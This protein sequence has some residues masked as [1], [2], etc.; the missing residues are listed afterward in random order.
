[1]LK[2]GTFEIVLR[3]DIPQNT[4]VLKGRFFLVVKHKDTKGELFKARYVVQG[5]ADPLMKQ[6]VHN[7]PNLRQDISR[8]ILAMA[9][10]LGFETRTLDI[11]MAFLLATSTN[12]REQYLEPSKESNRSSKNRLKLVKSLYGLCESGDRWHSPLRHHPCNRLAN[13]TVDNRY[14]SVLSTSC[15]AFNRNV[16]L[17]C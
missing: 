7:S 9:S 4:T 14:R 8:L 5:F 2:R 16:R 6:A 13:G 10:V 17:L 12:M 1:L 11:S 15:R 3:D